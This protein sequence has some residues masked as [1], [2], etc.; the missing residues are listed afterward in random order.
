MHL[1]E[2]IRDPDVHIHPPLD[3]GGGAKSKDTSVSKKCREMRLPLS[4]MPAP[5]LIQRGVNFLLGLGLGEGVSG[6][7]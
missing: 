2:S 4:A 1:E 6:V 3:V 5:S 7:V